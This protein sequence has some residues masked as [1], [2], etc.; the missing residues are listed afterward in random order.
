[1]QLSCILH[2]DIQHQFIEDESLWMI[3]IHIT[4]LSM[5]SIA[6][7]VRHRRSHDSE[8]RLLCFL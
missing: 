6:N 7:R 2:Y 3:Y 4:K 1:M 8:F 5:Q